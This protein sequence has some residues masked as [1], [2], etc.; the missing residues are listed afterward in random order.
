M[1]LRSSPVARCIFPAVA[2]L[3]F[4]AIAALASAENCVRIQVGQK[5]SVE[6]GALEIKFEAVTTDS[7]CPKGETCV[8]EGDAIV[9]LVVRSGDR[10]ATRLELHTSAKGPSVAGYLDW[11]IRLAALEPYPVT[12]RAIP[13]ADYVATLVV[14]HGPGPA[15]G[16]PTQ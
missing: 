3:A 13:P 11:N 7:R 1:V 2:G 10:P 8:W 15:D 9:A 16:L 14:G 4:L 5:I 12:G 6:S